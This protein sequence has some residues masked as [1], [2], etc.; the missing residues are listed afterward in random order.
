MP[1]EA[2]TLSI[3]LEMVIV[4]AELVGGVGRASQPEPEVVAVCRLGAQ[5]QP[6]ESARASSREWTLPPAPLYLL[7]PTFFPPR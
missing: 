5:P 2:T 3:L 7:F 6:Q 1:R 4:G